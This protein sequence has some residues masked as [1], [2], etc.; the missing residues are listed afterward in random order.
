MMSDLCWWLSLLSEPGFH[1]ELLICGPIQD[2]GLFVDA[3]TPWHIGIII[4]GKW[5]AFKEWKISGRDICWLKT[6]A[7]EILIY[8][9][10]AKGI[11]NAT[12]LIHFNNQDTIGSLDKGHSWNF[13]INLSICRTYIVLASLF[14]TPHLVYVTSG[15]NLVNPISCRELGIAGMCISVSFSLPDK[16]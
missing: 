8:I 12:L 3:S 11:Q 14:I 4:K 7:I 13:H 2:L 9:L 5:A 6:V 1:C 10:E 16:L 15:A